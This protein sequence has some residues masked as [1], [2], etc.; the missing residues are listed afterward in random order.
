MTD[1][2]LLRDYDKGIRLSKENAERLIE[3]AKMLFESKKYPSAFYLAVIGIEEI[4]KALLLLKYKKEQKEITKTQWKNVFCFH[5]EKLRIVEKAI[6]QHIRK[7]KAQYGFGEN[8]MRGISE[9]E[10]SNIDVSNMIVEGLK[11]DKDAFLY[12]GY[13]F[14][15]SVWS[16]PLKPDLFNLKDVVESLVHNYYEMAIFA[17]EKEMV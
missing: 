3:D 4:G 9:G 16:T 10:V 14:S 7:T 5:Q 1:Y 11:Q 6:T 8:A 13:D 17:L 12:V 15:R 2:P